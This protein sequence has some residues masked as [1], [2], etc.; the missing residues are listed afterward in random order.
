MLTA[1]D[2]VAAMGAA[3]CFG[4]GGGLSLSFTSANAVPLEAL[5]DGLV[6]GVAV[7]PTG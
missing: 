1:T 3:G 7:F 6:A 5:A 2:H 4:G